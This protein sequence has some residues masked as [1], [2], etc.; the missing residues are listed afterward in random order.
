MK[1]IIYQKAEV[2]YPA[3]EKGTAQKRNLIQDIREKLELRPYPQDIIEV[4]D[5]PDEDRMLAKEQKPLDKELR[6]EKREQKEEKE[7]DT[8]SEMVK[9]EMSVWVERDKIEE[10][11]KSMQDFYFNHELPLRDLVISEKEQKTK[12]ET[13]IEILKNRYVAMASNPPL[14]AYAN[15]NQG[16]IE[17]Y[18]GTMKDLERQ[19]R[20]AG[21][22][23]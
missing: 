18:E 12:Q 19:L 5:Y 15:H 7:S 2:D 23:S 17:D 20:E 4:F 9:V 3:F 13:E 1:I 10:F 11:N 21:V 8:M 16:V 22:I 6:H 14:S